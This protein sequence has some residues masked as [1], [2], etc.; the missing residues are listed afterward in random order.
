MADRVDREPS[1]GIK[2]HNFPEQEYNDEDD[3]DYSNVYRPLCVML[4]IGCAEKNY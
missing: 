4:T 1:G 3:D 2:L